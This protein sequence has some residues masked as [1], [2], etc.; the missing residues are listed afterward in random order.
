MIVLTDFCVHQAG[1]LEEVG[2]GRSRHQTGYRHA[3]ILEFVAQGKGEAVDE[4]LGRIV[5]G[6][7]RSGDETRDRSCDQDL[8]PASVA[9]VAA[10]QMKQFERT[11]DIG[12]DHA[13]HLVEVLIEKCLAQPMAGI[14]GQGAHGAPGD[15]GEQPV[16]PVGRRQIDLD[17][18]D[19]AWA[20][21]REPLPGFGD[22]GLIRGDDQVKPILGEQPG[23]LIADAGGGARDDG[24]RAMGRG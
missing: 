21:R 24:E 10:D 7:E 4:G 18:L 19:R 14:G 2:V 11:G 20:D 6:L 8:A 13:L 1:P 3:A 16:H 17:G 15:D 12:G 22:A 5:D 23:E 9:H